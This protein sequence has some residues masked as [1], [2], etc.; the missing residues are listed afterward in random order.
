M[1]KSHAGAEEKHDINSH[2]PKNTQNSAEP[3]NVPLIQLIHFV[4]LLGKS[5]ATFLQT[6]LL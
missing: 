1:S 5:A 2:C 6:K 4:K 3:E